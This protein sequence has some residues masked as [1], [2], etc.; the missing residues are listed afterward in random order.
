[1][2]ARALAAKD[3]NQPNGDQGE[4]AADMQGQGGGEEVRGHG[5]TLAGEISSAD[6]H[7]ASRGGMGRMRDAMRQLFEI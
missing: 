7:G 4:A 3:W 6:T 5:L 2:Q 1:M